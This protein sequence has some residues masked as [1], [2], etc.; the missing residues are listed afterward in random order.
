VVCYHGRMEEGEKMKSYIGLA[1]LAVMG[2]N[3][4]LNMERSGYAVSVYNRTRS[5]TDEF[6][7]KSAV[8]KNITATFSPE[9]FVNSIERPRKL[10]LMVKAGDAVDNLIEQLLPFLDKGDIIIDGGN[11][12]FKDTENRQKRLAEKGLVFM[13]VGVSGGEEGALKGPCVMPGGSREGYEQVAELLENIAAKTA[14]GSCCV[15]L[16]EG[17]AGHFVKMVH[18]GIEYGLMQIL[19]EIYDFFRHVLRFSVNEIS[20]IFYKWNEGEGSSFLLEITAHLLKKV[21]GETGRPLVDMISDVGGQKGTGIWTLKS[22]LDLG[23]PLP[24][25]SAAVSERTISGS[26][27]RLRTD[28]VQSISDEGN[29]KE[30]VSK[31][32][33]VLLASGILSYAQGM[34]LLAESKKAYGFDIPLADVA[35]IWQGGC[36][37][38]SRAL[39]RFREFFTA[40]PEGENILLGK[41]YAEEIDSMKGSLVTFVQVANKHNMSV[42]AISASLNYFLSFASSRLPMN[43]IQ[44]QRDYFGA[45][46]Y[47]RV[48]RDGTF[49]SD[50]N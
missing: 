45:H 12:H 41:V 14:D 48:D 2:R 19:A 50:W 10:F 32:Y 31:A 30:L 17:G 8:G 22:G 49:H 5:K 9:E 26:R 24:T 29:R 27:N 23:I 13:G 16:G 7:S 34:E 46:T 33:E 43:I 15:Y 35:R 38:R 28:I 25:I 20:D 42:P 47:K 44:A 36:I 1:G 18:N 37:I 11:C 40:S 3:L 4:V 21:D 6:M 39:E